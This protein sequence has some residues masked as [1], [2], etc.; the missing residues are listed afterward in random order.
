MERQR[1]ADWEKQRKEELIAHRQREQDKLLE[2]KAR[3]ENLTK[4]L[5]NMV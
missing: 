4:D 1:L 5:D 3:Q 2:L